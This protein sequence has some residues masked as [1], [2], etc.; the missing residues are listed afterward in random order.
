MTLKPSEVDIASDQLRLGVGG[1]L[2]LVVTL[3]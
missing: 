1:S 3:E 2:E